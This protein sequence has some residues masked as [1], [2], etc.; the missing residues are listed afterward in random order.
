MAYTAT[1]LITN[2]WYLSGIVA[3]NLETVSGDQTTDGLYLLNVLLDFKATDAR[4]IPYFTLYT[5]NLLQGQEVYFIPGLYQV[6]TMTFNYNEVRYSM[7]ELNRD[8]Y[9]GAARVNNIQSLPFN[10]HVERVEDGANIYVYYLPN[11][12]YP[13]T[14]VGKFGLTDVTLNE[15]LTTVYDNFYIEYLRYA[16]ADMMCQEYDIVFAPQKARMLQIYEKKL[17]DVS[18]PDLSMRKFS[19]LQRGTTLDWAQVNIGHGWSID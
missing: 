15:D 18:P 8:K 16:L 10:F 12:T 11:V 3:R 6:E 2:S 14:I 17:Q 4:L 19:S 9:F 1:Q 13:A 5:F 7:I